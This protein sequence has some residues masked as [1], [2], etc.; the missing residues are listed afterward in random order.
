MGDLRRLEAITPDGITGVY[1]N[2]VVNYLYRKQVH[3]SWSWTTNHVSYGVEKGAVTGTIELPLD[4][5]PGNG[6]AQMGTALP[7]SQETSI[8]QAR[9]IAAPPSYVAD[10]AGLKFVY[11]SGDNDA[12][13]SPWLNARLEEVEQGHACLAKKRYYRNCHAYAEKLSPTEGPFFVLITYHI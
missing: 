1:Q 5:T 3:R 11:L 13:E 9:N 4:F 12:A 10:R 8:F 6:A 2:L 7:K